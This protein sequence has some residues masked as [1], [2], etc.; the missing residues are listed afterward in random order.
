MYDLTCFPIVFDLFILLFAVKPS[1]SP[2]ATDLGFLGIAFV[3]T[4]FLFRFWAVARR[5]CLRLFRGHNGAQ[6]S[7]ENVRMIRL[8]TKFSF[9]VSIV[10]KGSSCYWWPGPSTQHLVSKRG[11]SKRSEKLCW[12][13]S[14]T[15]RQAPTS[16]TVR[17]SSA[18]LPHVTSMN[19]RKKLIYIYIISRTPFP[20]LILLS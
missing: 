1:T 9:I 3:L 19:A 2:V 20:N 12:E 11:Q 5:A 15:A 16:G 4:A 8:I 6:R 7:D 14:I 18:T 10:F 17:S 13:R